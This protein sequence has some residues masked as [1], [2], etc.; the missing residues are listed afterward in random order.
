[1]GVPTERLDAGGLALD[2]G[3]EKRDLALVAFFLLLEGFL[4]LFEAFLGDPVRFLLFEKLCVQ[5][6]DLAAEERDLL[7][8]CRAVHVGT[9]A[10]RHGVVLVDLFVLDVR[11]AFNLDQRCDLEL[12]TDVFFVGGG[13]GSE[14]LAQRF[15]LVVFARW[16]GK[17]E[18]FTASVRLR[19]SR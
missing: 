1:M 4:G 18:G 6:V 14:R 17:R 12:Q 13:Q 8:D 11:N 5:R 15:Q 3:V 7:R 19:G 2:F 10:V 16:E 9:H